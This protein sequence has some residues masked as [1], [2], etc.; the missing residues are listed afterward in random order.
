MRGYDQ[1]DLGLSLWLGNCSR[2]RRCGQLPPSAKLQVKKLP[3]NAESCYKK[4]DSAN[5]KRLHT[6]LKHKVFTVN[7]PGEIKSKKTSWNKVLYLRISSEN[8][9]CSLIAGY[10]Y[11][12]KIINILYC[13][14][15]Q[16]FILVFG[17]LL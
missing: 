9:E 14:E 17:A 1:P 13:N 8:G 11:F 2:S 6:T 16:G 10:S 5:L 4:N 3:L 15:N 12:G 7:S